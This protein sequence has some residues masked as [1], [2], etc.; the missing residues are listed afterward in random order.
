MNGLDKCGTLMKAFTLFPIPGYNKFKASLMWRRGRDSNPRGALTP[1]RFRVD[2]VMA[3]S[4]PLQ[5]TI[6]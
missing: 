3:T 5:W 6:I 2:A 1:I 4:V